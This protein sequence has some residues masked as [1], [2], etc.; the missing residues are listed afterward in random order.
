MTETRTE[1]ESA[2]RE[3]HELLA[4]IPIRTRPNEVG[5]QDGLY[6]F[7]EDD[8]TS[9][10][11]PTGRVVRVGNHPRSE[12]GLVRRL[13]QHYSGNKNGSVFRKLLGSALLRSRDPDTP[14]LAPAPGK[15][16]WE[17]QGARP[18]ALCR[19]LE[20][21]VSSSLRAGFRFRCIEIRDRNERNLFEVMLVATLAQCQVCKPSGGWL[22]RHA[23]VDRVRES[24]LWN[25]QY[26][27]GRV[28]SKAALGRFA[29]LVAASTQSGARADG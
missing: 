29:E 14:C 12:G 24:G 19:V 23:Y 5:F 1:I 2:C 10:H 13:R 7:F 26:S 8:E 11:G 27:D 17:L 25:V 15:G 9:R 16:H 4:R 28:L 21:E 6:F 20:A 22:G 3:V 18:C